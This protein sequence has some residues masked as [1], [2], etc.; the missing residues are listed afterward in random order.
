[1][2]SSF[3]SHT[4]QYLSSNPDPAFKR[5]LTAY[6][7]PPQQYSTLSPTAKTTSLC[8]L[9]L[10]SS[11]ARLKTF[12]STSVDA[13]IVRFFARAEI[14]IM[15]CPLKRF[16]SAREMLLLGCFLGGV[17]PGSLEILFPLSCPL[18]ARYRRCGTSCHLPRMIH[19]D[20]LSLT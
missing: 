8:Y 13:M 2:S 19:R 11:L 6:K 16:L 15:V 17:F 18:P 4:T 14:A 12:K 10:R 20:G 5:S 9:R 7:P 3:F 1:V